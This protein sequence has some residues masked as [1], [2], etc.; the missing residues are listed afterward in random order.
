MDNVYVD[1]VVFGYVVAICLFTATLFGFAP[2]FHLV[3]SGAGESIKEAGR[4]TTS[5]P[6]VRRLSNLLIVSELALTIVL[7]VGAG[8][9]IR[10]FVTLYRVELGIGISDLMAMRVSLPARSTPPQKRD[11]RSSTA[12]GS[13]ERHTWIEASAVTTGVPP[14]TA[15]NACSKSKAP[16]RARMPLRYSS[17]P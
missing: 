16:V 1:Y 14:L 4:G 7:L 13:R 3:K 15:E 9:L 17:G 11:A 2:A 10:A 6:R 12:R 5:S 8:S